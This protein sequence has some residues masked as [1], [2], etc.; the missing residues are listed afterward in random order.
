MCLYVTDS[1]QDPPRQL[2]HSD[3][4]YGGGKC[5]LQGGVDAT[6][7]IAELVVCGTEAEEFAGAVLHAPEATLEGEGREGRVNVWRCRDGEG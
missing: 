1:M 7:R 6:E 5:I 4:V 2:R 3:H